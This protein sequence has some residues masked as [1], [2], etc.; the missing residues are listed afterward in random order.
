[1]N[2]LQSFF[3]FKKFPHLIIAFGALALVC[4]GCARHNP[5][6]DMTQLQ[7]REIQTR[8]FTAKEAKTVLKEMI[9]VMQD[10]AFIVKNA[11]LEL[12]FVTGEKDCELENGWEKWMTVIAVGH[13][14]SWTKNGI[15]ELSANV[16][17]F[18]LDT[19][20]RINFQRKLFDNHGRVVEVKQV[21]DQEYYQAFFD[22]VHKGLFIQEE[23]I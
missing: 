3:S 19:K 2:K 12:G 18:G 17:Q 9:N 5:E 6:D 7:I 8:T 21:Y 15:T 1:M 13:N 16:T 20:V 11:N 23:K 22:K 10:D 4:S 14:G